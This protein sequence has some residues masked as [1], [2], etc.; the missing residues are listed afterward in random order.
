MHLP[1]QNDRRVQHLHDP[2]A[3]PDDNFEHEKKVKLEQSDDEWQH[4]PAN[5]R[6]WTPAKKWTTTAIVAL[7]TFVTPL[8]SSIMAP[9]LPDV[10]KKI[11][12]NQSNNCSLDSKYIPSVICYRSLIRR[13]LVRSI[14]S[15]TRTSLGESALPRV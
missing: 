6:N 10:A 5:P 14:R 12:H 4:D 15:F 13:A 8:A 2:S 3:I 1:D 11:Q 9:G 7:Y